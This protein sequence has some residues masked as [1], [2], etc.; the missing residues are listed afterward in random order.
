MWRVPGDRVLVEPQR[1]A[2]APFGA[3]PVDAFDVERQ[4]VRV[5]LS[6]AGVHAQLALCASGVRGPCRARVGVSA[7]SVFLI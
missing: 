1:R 7:I 3:K 5:E 4:P 2:R 6:P